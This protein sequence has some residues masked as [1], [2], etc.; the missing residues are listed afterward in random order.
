MVLRMG[1]HQMRKL[2]IA[3]VGALIFVAFGSIFS[4]LFSHEISLTGIAVGTVVY[5]VMWL[6]LPKR[7]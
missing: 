7:K 2:L 5:F 1:L 3:V 4:E 6:V